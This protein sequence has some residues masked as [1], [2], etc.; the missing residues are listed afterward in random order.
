VTA[1]HLV[2]GNAQTFSHDPALEFHQEEAVIAALQEPSRHLGPLRQGP[3]L[4]ERRPGLAGLPPRP[5]LGRDLGPDIVEEGVPQVLVGGEVPAGGSSLFAGRRTRI[6]SSD[7]QRSL[8]PSLAPG[9]DPY[10]YSPRDQPYIDECCH[11]SSTE[12][13]E[14]GT[15]YHWLRN[16][17]DNAPTHHSKPLLKKAGLPRSVRFHDLRHTCVTLLRPRNVNP[18]VIEEML[19]HANISQTMDIYSHLL[20]NMQDEAAAAM[21]SALT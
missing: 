14:R 19:D 15:T 20:P 18:K 21:E 11:S 8:P 10:P 6:H 12:Q 3:R 2:W 7:A 4:G 1:G 16:R 5:R 13:T 9:H 17:S